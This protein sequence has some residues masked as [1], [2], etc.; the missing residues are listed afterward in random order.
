MFDPVSP[1][2]SLFAGP[3]PIDECLAWPAP[4]HD[5]PLTVT[6]PLVPPTLPVLILSGDLDSITAPGDAEQARRELGPSAMVVTLPNSA[7][8]STFYD[9]YDC[10]QRIVRAFIEHPGTRPDTACT[11]RIAEVRAVGVFP[12]LL[13]DEPPASPRSGDRATRREARAAALAIAAVGDAIESARYAAYNEGLC[14]RRAYCGRGLRGGWF[15]STPD[16]T[17]VGLYRYAFSY[18]TQVTGFVRISAENVAYGAGRVTARLVVRAKGD[19]IVET[20]RAT[21]DERV[22][23]ARATVDGRT[24]DGRPI[25]EETPAP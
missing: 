3:L 21:W 14:D 10:A 25:H 8:S 1:S 5:D 22:P 19:H 6:A 12:E 11:A 4:A 2:A 15:V 13:I 9:A 17:K 18:D 20:L 7:H 16:A 24:Q 23:Q